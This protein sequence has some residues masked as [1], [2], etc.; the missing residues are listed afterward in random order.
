VI[1]ESL[2]KEKKLKHRTERGERESPLNI[3][4]KRVVD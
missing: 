2:A 1:R 3:R 4:E